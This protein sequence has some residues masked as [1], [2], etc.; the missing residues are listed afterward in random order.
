MW[1][2]SSVTADEETEHVAIAE[3]YAMAARAV[4]GEKTDTDSVTSE[5]AGAKVTTKLTNLK[6]VATDEMV[7]V[8]TSR[9]EESKVH[10]NNDPPFPVKVSKSESVVAQET[11]EVAASLVAKV[12]AKPVLV[13]QVVEKKIAPKKGRTSPWPIPVAAGKGVEE[14]KSARIKEGLF[15]PIVLAA[16]AIL[17]M[18]DLKK[19][20]AKVIGYHSD[21]VK[22]FVGTSDSSFGETV[23]KQLFQLVDTDDSGYLDKEELAEALDL[24]GF[25]WL[26][27]KDVD[28]IFKKA[29]YN[30]D[31]QIS[32][33][34]FVQETPK[35][36]KV[37]LIKLAKQNGADMGLMV[38]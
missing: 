36:L 13:Q 4:S 32:L 28:K 23:L 30:K 8:A 22:S 6:S 14:K 17:G 11:P 26:G 18:D 38:T 1:L 3:R 12:K 31:G 20:R 2:D 15:S 24:L 7:D 9:R 29:D 21:I 5:S 33:E 27:Q 37:Q 19:L 25:K 16:G 10:V 35:V 34:E